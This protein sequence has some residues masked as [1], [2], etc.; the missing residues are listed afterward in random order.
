MVKTTHGKI[1]GKIIELDQDLGLGEGQDVEVQV[2]VVP[3][4]NRWGEGLK[5]SAGALA[6][7]WNED[8]DRVLE[9]IRQDRKRESRRAVLE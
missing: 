1:R 9:E 3:A 6:Q 5:R 8:D 4:R 7:E 2:K